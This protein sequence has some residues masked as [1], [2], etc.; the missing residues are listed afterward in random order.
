VETSFIEG[1]RKVKNIM[2]KILKN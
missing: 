2:H 1:D